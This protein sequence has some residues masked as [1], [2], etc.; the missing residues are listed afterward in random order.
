MPDHTPMY[1][2]GIQDDV[3]LHF[4]DSVY[5]FKMPG[6]K[7]KVHRQLCSD[8][9]VECYD[10][11]KCCLTDSCLFRDVDCQSGTVCL[12]LFVASMSLSFCVQTLMSLLSTC[13]SL[14]M[15]ALFVVGK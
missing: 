8:P 6:I 5:G 4:W 3:R 9:V 1:I 13:E 7:S 10:G 2:T 14:L 11:E 15:G 12:P